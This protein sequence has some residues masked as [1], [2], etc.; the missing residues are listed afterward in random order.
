MNDQLGDQIT[1]K[2]RWIDS[3][4]PILNPR[5]N[6][7]SPYKNEGIHLLSHWFHPAAPGPVEHL[8]HETSGDGFLAKWSNRIPSPFFFSWNKTEWWT[9]N[10]VLKNAPKPHGIM[11]LWVLIS[12]PCGKHPA[13]QLPIQHLESEVLH[14][15]LSFHRFSGDKEVAK[16]GDFSGTSR[17]SLEKSVAWVPLLKSVPGEIVPVTIVG[18]LLYPYVS[19]PNKGESF[20]ICNPPKTGKWQLWEFNNSTTIFWRVFD[21]FFCNKALTPGKTTWLW[22]SLLENPENPLVQLS[23][24]LRWQFTEIRSNHIQ[25]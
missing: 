21:H 1:V 17:K 9:K 5:V 15:N 23:N 10:V 24:I 11:G 7:N 22:A 25:I 18:V 2:S 12:W 20:S 3:S 19:I 4:S 13:A 16:S 6:Q 14:G 8:S